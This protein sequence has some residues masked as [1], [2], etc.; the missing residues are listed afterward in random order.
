[1]A[2]L[3]LKIQ[4]LIFTFF[5]Y[6]LSVSAF[7]LIRDD[8]S[9]KRGAP[10]L[11][12]SMPPCSPLFLVDS[13]KTDWM[14]MTDWR[15][16]P[17]CWFILHG[18]VNVAVCYLHITVLVCHLQN[19][20]PD[21]ASKADGN[22]A[23]QQQQLEQF[24]YENDKLKIALAQRLYSQWIFSVCLPYVTVDWVTGRVHS[25][26]QHLK[27]SLFL[28]NWSNSRNVVQWDKH[29]HVVVVL[30]VAV[31]SSHTCAAGVCTLH[32]V[33]FLSYSFI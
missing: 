18:T 3:S 24:R 20:S 8:T 31:L 14:W 26:L 13:L 5:S 7:P 28:L 33:I 1:M 12:K 9:E 6:F 29:A 2:E 11:S 16:C 10:K 30:L 25:L 32:F 15:L 27:S 19:N 22:I 4:A 23:T 21:G 17:L